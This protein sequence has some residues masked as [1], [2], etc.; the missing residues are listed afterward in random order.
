MGNPFAFLVYKVVGVLGSSYGYL[1]FDIA[2]LADLLI[3]IHHHITSSVMIITTNS[4][5]V[6]P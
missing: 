6:T 2:N 1:F 5:L 4:A 3:Y